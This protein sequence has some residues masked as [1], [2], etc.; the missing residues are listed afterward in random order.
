ML[1][2]S[3]GQP[4]VNLRPRICFYH[5]SKFVLAP[6][7]YSRHY[8]VMKRILIC[9]F[10][11]AAAVFCG[12]EHFIFNP[13]FKVEESGLNWVSIRHYN[14]KATPIQRVSVRID[15]NGIVTVREGASI[16]VTNPFAAN[17]QDAHWDDIRETRLTLTREEMVPLFQ[18][19]V[20]KGLFKERVNNGKT[21]SVTNEAIF[22]SANIGGKACGSEDDVY[23]IDPELAEHLK[24]VMLMFYHPHPKNRR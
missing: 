14:Y 5:A 10:F 20:D 3:G 16:L 2:L 1:S 13:Y 7:A 9:S 6:L 23:A 21:S 22:V 12:C 18:M 4:F 19:L 24:M 8:Y 15:G 11:F 17:S